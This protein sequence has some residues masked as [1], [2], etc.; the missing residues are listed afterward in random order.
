M[1]PNLKCMMMKKYILDTTTVSVDNENKKYDLNKDKV[2][3][4]ADLCRLIDILLSE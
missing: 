1:S 3:N 2:V 4:A